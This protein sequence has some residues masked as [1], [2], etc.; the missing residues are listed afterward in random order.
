[1]LTPVPNIFWRVVL[2][3]LLGSPSSGIT[4]S[5][6]P[7]VEQTLSAVVGV[8]AQVPKSA[9]TARVL[10]TERAGSGVVIDEHGLVVTI[11][12]V[13]LEASRVALFVDNGEPVEAEVIGYDAD[14]GLGLLRAR[15]PIDVSPM[16][17]GD[18]SALAINAPV[19]ISSF[20]T[21]RPVRPGIVVSRQSFAGFWEYVLDSPIIVAPPYPLFGGAALIGARGDLLGIGSLTLGGVTVGDARVPANMFVP[22]DE[23]KTVMASLLENGRSAEPSRPWLGVYTEERNG[24]LLITRLAEDGPASQAGLTRGDIITGVAQEPVSSLIQFYRTLWAQG[25]AGVNVTLTVLREG[26]LLDVT[27]E[28]ADRYS[29]YRIPSS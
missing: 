20:G 21:P 9:R 28:S 16:A 18:S 27:V 1:M 19:L 24:L 14:S 3:A 10:G 17:L 29:W 6:D 23:L 2:V 25:D 7:A 22:I 12:Y 4:Q 11:G 13:L 5:L 15:S 26:E 8:V